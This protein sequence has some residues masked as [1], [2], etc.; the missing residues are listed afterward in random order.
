M[1][2]RTLTAHQNTLSSMQNVLTA[3]GCGNVGSRRSVMFRDPD[4]DTLTV[5]AKVRGDLP[6]NV[7][8]ADGTPF[9][10]TTGDVVFL[11]G[12]AAYEATVVENHLHFTDFTIDVT[13]TDPH[14]A[15][16][17]TFFTVLVGHL[18]DTKAPRFE[19]Q[20]ESLSF[21]KNEAIEPVVLPA[22]TGGDVRGPF[23]GL[24]SRPYEFPYIYEVTGLPPGLAFDAATR[25]LSGTPTR[26][27]T[28][29]MTYTAGD[30]DSV[31]DP[32]DEASQTIRVQ[33][34]GGPQIDRVRI[35]SKPTYDSDGDGTADTYVRDDEILIDVEF[36]EPVAVG[37]DGNVRLR[38]DV[39]TDD[40][41]QGN[42]R[43]TVS[44][45]S[46]LHNGQTLRFVYTVAGH[47][48]NPNLRDR[49]A[50]GVWVQTNAAGTAVFLPANANP[51]IS[52]TLTHAVTGEDADLTA[53]WLPT[54]GD[55]LHKVDGSKMTTTSGRS[56]PARR[57]TATR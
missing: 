12:V 8:L 45:Y 13:A 33:V 26:A 38:L 22:A 46:V 42:S 10:Q 11:Q 19:A 41:N 14:G 51:A 7:R 35:V 40:T 27:G 24:T 49:D 25:T 36:D 39:G 5:T 15:S 16:V 20:A 32:S 57:W 3:E 47:D 37:G 17:S 52:P 6:D 43:K 55:P 56:R 23:V 29:T 1:F 31:Q 28:F 9:V 48:T 34:P 44:T 50:D 4:G 2:E 53:G 30:A 21:T 18:P 54:T